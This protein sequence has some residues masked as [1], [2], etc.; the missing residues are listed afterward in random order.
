MVKIVTRTRM[1]FL[2]LVDFLGLMKLDDEQDE[3]EDVDV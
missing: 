1:R 3:D 2:E